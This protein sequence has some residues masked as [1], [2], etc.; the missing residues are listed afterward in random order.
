M[1]DHLSDAYMNRIKASM[2]DSFT[3]FISIADTNRKIIYFNPAAYRMMG[4]SPDERPDI[5]T[6]E[7]LHTKEADDIAKEFIQPSVF[8]KGFWTGISYIKHKDGSP[9]KVEMTVF[10]LYGPNGEEYGTV[11][12]MRDVN[13]LTKMNERLKKSSELFQKVLD[14]SKIGIVL[15][16]METNIIEMVNQY[17]EELLQMKSEEI[18]GKKCFDIL[19]HQNPDLCPHVNERDKQVLLGERFLQRKDGSFLP[20]IKTGTWINIDNKDYLVDTFVDISIQKELENNLNDARIAAEAAN[21]SKSEFLSRMSHEMR[22][23]LNAIIGMTQITDKTD[24]VDKLRECIETIKLS[25]NH[26]LSLINDVL[27]LSKIEEGKLE[28]NLGAFSVS[29]MIQ[30]IAV[31]IEP[32]VKEKNIRLAVKIDAG[33]P[34]FLIGDSLRISQVLLNFLSNSVKFTPKDSEMSVTVKMNSKS[35]GSVNLH[36]SVSDKGIGITEDQLARL[37]SPFVQADGTI[38]RKYGGTGLG[39]VISKR[40]INIMGSD[41]AVETKYGEGSTFSFDLDLPI[42]REDDLKIEDFKIEDIGGIFKDKKVLLVDDVELNRII[43][44]ELLAET[45][46]VFED[47]CDG[48]EA[49]E[50]A[51]Q[52]KYDIILMDIQMP[53]MDGYEATRLIR[54][55]DKPFSEVPIVAMSANVFKEDV[56]RSLSEG[57]DAHIG[58]PVDVDK[59]VVVINSLVNYGDP[60]SGKLPTIKTA[61]FKPNIIDIGFDKSYFNYEMA[62]DMHDN[63]NIALAILCNEFI[64]SDFYG[65]LESAMDSGDYIK[66]DSIARILVQKS[67]DFALPSLAAYAG[68]LSE[69]LKR[70]HYDYAKMYLNDLHKCYVKTCEVMSNLLQV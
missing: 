5:T 61:T 1:A 53:V 6:T 59:M 21:R 15:I 49:V 8:A 43:V 33:I 18:V 52:T 35:K 23:P 55:M 57:M 14:S 70:G 54:A 64:Q 25:S 67:Q 69:T 58:K 28:L 26:L 46:I 39:L 32:K 29:N 65:K 50:K 37:F 31:L 60:E 48:K 62:L 66:A 4:Y 20:I 13:E 68:T 40:L 42:A 63:N 30:K 47:A 17:T 51:T 19:C 2:I 45:G 38:T 34:P 16:N 36:F 11:A 22:T 24:S 9:I 44:H 27:D 10:P 3:D 7:Q 56:E 12:V 41:I